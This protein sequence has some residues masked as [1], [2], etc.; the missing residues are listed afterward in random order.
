[1]E[2]DPT[3]TDAAVAAVRQWKAK[4]GWIGGKKVDVITTVTFNFQLR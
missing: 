1:L 4:P 2:G 3:L